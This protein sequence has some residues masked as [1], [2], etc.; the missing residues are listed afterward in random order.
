MPTGAE[1][2]VVVMEMGMVGMGMGMGMQMVM[3]IW[4]KMTPQ[5]WES[6]PDPLSENC[7]KE[8]A[9]KTWVGGSR[10]AARLR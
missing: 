4:P 3:G 6:M 9:M 8:E 5:P 2:I 7:F 1:W 10:F